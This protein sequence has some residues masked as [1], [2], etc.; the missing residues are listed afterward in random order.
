MNETSN[1]PGNNTLPQGTKPPMGG[2]SPN[3]ATSKAQAIS[4]ATSAIDKV[5][6]AENTTPNVGEQVTT[7]TDAEGNQVE[8]GLKPGDK[9]APGMEVGEDGKV[10]QSSV[11]RL[12]NIAGQGAAAYFSGGNADAVEAV[13]NA[14]NSKTGQK[15]IGVVSDTVEKTPGG[16]TVKVAADELEKAGVDDALEGATKAILDAKNGDLA[17]AMEGAK[18]LKEGKKKLRGYLLKKIVIACVIVLSPLILAFF[19]LFILIAGI[20]DE[21]D[22]TSKQVYNNSADYEWK[23]VEDEGGP[24]DPSAGGGGED[25]TFEPIDDEKV[26]EIISQIPG[27]DSL[28]NKRK[29]IIQ[30]ALSAVGLPYTYNSKPTG[31]GLSGIPAAGLDCSGFVEWAYWTGLGAKQGFGGT[32]NIV[33]NSATWFNSVSYDQMKPGDVAVRRTSEGGHTAIYLGNDNW[34]HASGRKVG[35]IVKVNKNKSYYQYHYTYRGI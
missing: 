8:T 25:G 17:G 1:V 2:A 11:A 31:P 13:R 26:K 23:D 3:G 19:L 30:A 10:K 6:G 7:Q 32:A 20:Q 16:Q 5:T 12:T 28:S 34:V 14:E 29:S 24:E 22:T 15:L 18:Q 9:I 33:S 4:Q 27:W 35:I 21:N